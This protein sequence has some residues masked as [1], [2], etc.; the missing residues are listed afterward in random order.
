M[1]DD[2]KKYVVLITLTLLAFVAYSQEVVKDEK[3]FETFE[4]ADGAG[5]THLK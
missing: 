2:M 4:M 3:G 5:D 1:I